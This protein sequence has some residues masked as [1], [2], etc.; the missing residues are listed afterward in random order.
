MGGKGSG[1]AR[2]GSGNK[3]VRAE[4][5]DAVFNRRGIAFN[6]ELYQYDLVDFEPEN[7]EARFMEYLEICDRHG[8]KPTV[9]GVSVACGLDSSR[10]ND[11]AHGNR[12]SYKGWRITPETVQAFQKVYKFLESVL[13]NYLS[14]EGKNPAKWIFLA[15]N[16][17]GYTDTRE[18]IVT[19]REDAPSLDTAED[20]AKRL[21][22]STS[23]PSPL[24]EAEIMSIENIETV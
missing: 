24:P 20:I 21:G 12:A 11:I 13:E 17:F 1:G 7:I 18:Q 15:K 8:M 2:P 3:G 14:S 5:V 4:N 10:F 9:S 19:R 6:K 23:A 16:H 22:I